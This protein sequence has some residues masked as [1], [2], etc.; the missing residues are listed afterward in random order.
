MKYELEDLLRVRN[1]RKDRASDAL[2]KAQNAL[3]E[4]KKFCEQ[5][6]IKLEMFVQKKPGFI[7]QIYDKL[8]QKPQFKRNYMDLIAFKIGKLDEHQS[9]LAIALQKAQNLEEEAAKKVEQCKAALK[10]ATVEMNKIEE[11]K[12]T[13]KAEVSAL[14]QF[15]QDKELE[16][17]KVK[18]NKE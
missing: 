16:D 11:H 2:I 5:Q 12:I 6:K 15:E 10:Q 3:A 8:F 9:K 13:W 18:S 17:F 4:A 1:L 7:R 14:E